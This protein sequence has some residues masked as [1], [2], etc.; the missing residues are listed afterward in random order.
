M[1][2]Y[3][4]M[5]IDTSH[6]DLV[7]Q[8]NST[9]ARALTSASLEASENSTL[10]GNGLRVKMIQEKDAMDEKMARLEVKMDKMFG[11]TSA[12]KATIANLEK[13]VAERGLETDLLKICSDG[14]LAIRSRYIDVYR[15]DILQVSDVSP[16]NIRS[17]NQAA[18]HG[19]AFVDAMLYERGLR[20]DSH[21]LS[22]IYGLDYLTILK[23]CKSCTVLT[24]H[25][26]T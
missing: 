8:A 19:D 2:L 4:E 24:L 18:H 23:L 21:I 25:K 17:G 22:K 13:T 7:Q 11:E 1:V 5:Q 12:L 15:R 3:D 16:A 9:M 20:N 10:Y 26:L 14:Y 6:H